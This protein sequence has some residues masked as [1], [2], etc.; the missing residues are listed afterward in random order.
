MLKEAFDSIKKAIKYDPNDAES[1]MMISVLYSIVGKPELAKPYASKAI[2][3]DPLNP[4][5]Y[6]GCFWVHVSEGKLD[7]L[8]EYTAKM[9]KLDTDNISS[10]YVY[11]YALVV[12]NRTKEANEVY[13]KAIDAYP[14]S[15]PF[16]QIFKGYRYAINNDYKKALQS[17]TSELTKAAE[18]DHLWAWFL[19]DLYSMIEEKDK[20]I[21]FVER[22]TRENINYPFF[23]NMI[24]FS[25]TSV[26]KSVSKS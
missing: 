18:M 22:A 20:A 19:A 17:I 23:Q 10:A 5:V 1:L 11:A 7:L 9:Y 8:L 21:D 24:L 15:P 26:V 2:K 6:F 4:I 14:E 13:D 3:I 16:S 12:N 25:K